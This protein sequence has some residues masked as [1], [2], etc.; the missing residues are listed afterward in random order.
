M[1]AHR[2]GRSDGTRRRR[3]VGRKEGAGGASP[4]AEETALALSS[5]SRSVT[6]RR[7]AAPQ[8]V[9]RGS[10]RRGVGGF[11]LLFAFRTLLVFAFAF[12]HSKSAD[13]PPRLSESIHNSEGKTNLRMA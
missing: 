12:C 3:M 8:P 1:G 2:T 10:E 13:G 11:V 5:P 7:T 6:R 4:V 9:T